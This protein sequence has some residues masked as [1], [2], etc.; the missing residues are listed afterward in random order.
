GHDD[1]QITRSSGLR[2]HIGSRQFQDQFAANSLGKLWPVVNRDHEG[3]RSADH[4]IRVVA[5]Q[6]GRIEDGGKT[7]SG[8]ERQP[9]YRDALLGDPVTGFRDWPALIIRA[10]AGNVYDAPGTL[11]PAFG[12]QIA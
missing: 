1:R 4:A 12:K 10:I 3:S 2:V 5:V 8:H 11:E 7:P 6:F 9:V